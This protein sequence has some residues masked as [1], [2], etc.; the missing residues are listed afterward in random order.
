MFNG[1]NYLQY[2]LSLRNMEKND[3]Q[4]MAVCKTQNEL[5][6]LALGRYEWWK[7]SVPMSHRELRGERHSSG[8]ILRLSKVMMMIISDDDV[9]ILPGMH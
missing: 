1:E 8:Q 2:L 9:L 4:E 6:C 7:L 3:R 5:K